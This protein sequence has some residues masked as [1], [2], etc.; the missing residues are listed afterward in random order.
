MQKPL[1][2]FIISIVLCFFPALIIHADVKRGVR[3][4]HP[5]PLGKKILYL[6]KLSG[7]PATIYS[8]KPDGSSKTPVLEGSIFELRPSPSGKEVLISAGDPDEHYSTEGHYWGAVHMHLWLVDEKGLRRLTSGNVRDGAASWSYD[9]K[10]IYFA[11]APTVEVHN[12]SELHMDMA[13]I[14]EMGLKSG[15]IKQLT[16]AEEYENFHPRPSPNG[17][18]IA[19]LSLRNQKPQIYLMDTNGKDETLFID[20]AMLGNW[21]PD[22]TRFAFL[23]GQPGDIFIA[24]TDGKVIKQLTKTDRVVSEPS[25]S[26]DGKRIVYSEINHEMKPESSPD[27]PIGHGDD[28]TPM[29]DI[30]VKEVD[31]DK[32]AVRLTRE[33]TSNS[34]PYWSK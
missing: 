22:G 4:L 13:N 23:R 26:P 24:S 12:Q 1:S 5:I 28:D 34:L 21:S 27:Y 20:D 3:I 11:R 29:E 8:M 19:F 7:F 2:I 17:K 18:K 32:P 31:N 16:H 14:W 15:E 33:G 25:W 30:L 9:G 10:K 6:H